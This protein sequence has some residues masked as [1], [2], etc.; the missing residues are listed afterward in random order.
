MGIIKRGQ[1]RRRKFKLIKGKACRRYR[2]VYAPA[3]FVSSLPSPFSPL[4]AGQPVWLAG[5]SVSP[6]DAIAAPRL[7]LSP[8]A[9]T[10]Q[11]RT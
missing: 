6:S 1:D 9:E 8:S 7:R 4:L 10:L 11:R 3:V 5:P 2:G